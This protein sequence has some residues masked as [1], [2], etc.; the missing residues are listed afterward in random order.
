M[1]TSLLTALAAQAHRTE[2]QCLL[3]GQTLNFKKSLTLPG[4]T[5]RLT[6]SKREAQYLAH[7]RPEQK[8]VHQGHVSVY[9]KNV[10]LISPRQQY[11][12]TRYN[13]VIGF[14]TV[15]IRRK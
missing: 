4:G 13:F 7:D 12:Y 10:D 1:P 11:K 14:R 15:K 6:F 8:K 5:R 3:E 2:G 9:V